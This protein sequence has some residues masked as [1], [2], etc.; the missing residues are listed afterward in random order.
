MC[1]YDAIFEPGTSELTYR[2]DDLFQQI[3]CLA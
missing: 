2:R 1:P 3:I